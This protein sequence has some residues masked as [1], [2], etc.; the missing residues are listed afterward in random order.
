MTVGI[1]GL[2]RTFSN[3]LQ[4]SLE[5]DGVDVEPRHDDHPDDPHQH[6]TWKHGHPRH[7]PRVNLVLAKHPYAWIRSRHRFA[8]GKRDPLCSLYER[9]RRSVSHVHIG[10]TKLLFSPPL[11]L[12][13]HA[14]EAWQV[15]LPNPMIVRYEAFLADPDR[16]YQA[17]G[18]H[19]D[20]DLTTPDIPDV[21]VRPSEDGP[22]SHQH[23]VDHSFYLEHRW[24]SW[25][26]QPEQ[27]W[28]ESYVHRHPHHRTID[29]L[30]YETRFDDL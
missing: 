28:I 27:R 30:G 1:W 23:E 15:I 12:Y 29:H 25:Y 22:R 9:V 21:E 19:I 11:D 24:T 18:D 20:Q 13:H 26:S 14:Y 10:P 8:L 4:R 7:P 17:I 5:L 16:V 3:L 2:R 6:A